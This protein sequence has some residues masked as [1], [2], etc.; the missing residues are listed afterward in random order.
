MPPIHRT[1]VARVEL[2]LRCLAED[3][4]SA[5]IEPDRLTKF[6]LA[7][8]SGPLVIGRRVRWEFMVEGAVTDVEAK[9]LEPHRRI[10][11]EWADG[12]ITEWS[13]E[14]RAEEGTVVAITQSGFKGS[15]EVVV[16]MALE[17]TQG[18]TIV[19]CELK[20][21]LEQGRAMNL[22]RDKAA[23]IQAG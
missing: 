11:L 4:Y 16:A 19:L 5:F 1:T 18:Y 9:A 13:F 17:A 15:A 23:L 7:R 6:W 12:S 3:A 21:L 14:A 10:V 8:A 2:L 20:L 22:V